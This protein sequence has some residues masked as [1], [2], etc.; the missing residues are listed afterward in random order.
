M[1]SNDL[2]T[3]NENDVVVFTNNQINIQS[4]NEI[5]ENVT[6]YDALGRLIFS[7]KSI[8]NKDFS[9]AIAKND[10]PLFIKIKLQNGVVV[11][12]KIIY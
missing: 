8:N 5:I 7:N 9:I 4:K 2:I 3:G 11:D 1:L 6:V 12:K 10:I